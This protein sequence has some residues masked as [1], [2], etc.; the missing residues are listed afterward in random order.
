MK[1][2]KALTGLRA[3]AAIWVLFFH[4][5]FGSLPFIPGVVASILTA[6]F[7]AVSLFFVLSGFILTYNYFPMEPS[8]QPHKRSGRYA[9]AR[10]ARI[11]PVY[12]LGFVLGAITEGQLLDP[13]NNPLPPLW[14]NVL[15]FFGLQNWTFAHDWINYPSWSVSCEIFF[16][17]TL[18]FLLHA[19]N[20]MKPNA[21]PILL[22]LSG[23]AATTVGVLGA[24]TAHGSNPE[25]AVRYLPLL[26]WPEFVTGVFLGYIYKLGRTPKF[27][28]SHGDVVAIFGTLFAAAVIVVFREPAIFLHSGGLTIPFAIVIVGLAEARGPI[29]RLLANP[30]ALA[31]GEASYSLYVLQ[32]PAKY[33][34]GEMWTHFAGEAAKP[35]WFR[36]V[37]FFGI[38]VFSVLVNK[39]F[40]N[41]ARRAILKLARS[42]SAPA[43]SPA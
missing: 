8:P 37:T 32:F 19:L 9:I 23:I 6:G 1:E 33:L 25:F 24:Y 16:Y 3:V 13:A 34:A 42:R 17:A 21:A 29:Y 41:P 15:T 2:L 5:S 43:A 4:S 20:R 38:I 14:L 31:L 7:A 39:L 22:L 26:R 36:G 40:E 27:I 18:P 11:A 28:E 10:F 35:N 30:I 12:F